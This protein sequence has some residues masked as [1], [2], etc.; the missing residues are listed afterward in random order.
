MR[1][2]CFRDCASLDT[3][4]SRTRDFLR[5]RLVRGLAKSLNMGIGYRDERSCSEYQVTSVNYSYG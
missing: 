3:A 5:S 2:R 1:E 4:P